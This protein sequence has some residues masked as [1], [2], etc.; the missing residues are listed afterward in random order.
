MKV[1]YEESIA[2]RI[3]SVVYQAETEN[4]RIGYIEVT[5]REANE[6]SLTMHRMLLAFGNPTGF[7]HRLHTI[8]DAGKKIGTY[9][10]AEIR[11]ERHL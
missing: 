5:V 10:G 11:V 2:K 8:G 3:Q 6:L 1:V 7:Q 4:R 9:C